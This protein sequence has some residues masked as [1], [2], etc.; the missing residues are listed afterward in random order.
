[1]KAL[2]GAFSVIV[3]TDGL[4]AALV[5]EE[6]VGEHSDGVDGGTLIVAKVVPR[7]PGQTASVLEIPRI[8]VRGTD[9]D[10]KH[11]KII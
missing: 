8:Y 2:V 5:L 6:G 11:I 10:N 4:F 9:L 7:V 3:K 1:M